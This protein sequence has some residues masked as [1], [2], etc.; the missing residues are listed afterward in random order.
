MSRPNDPQYSLRPEA[1]PIRQWKS[2]VEDQKCGLE[3]LLQL[4]TEAVQ[5]LDLKSGE[6]DPR[7]PWLIEDR[8]SQLSFIDGK[9]GAGKT[10]LMTTLVEWLSPSRISVEDA[11][12][13][14]EVVQLANGLRNRV[15]L[16]EPLDMEP[17]PLATPIM[18]AI[19]ARVN[20]AV[21]RLSA[22][23]TS[24]RGML[25]S[26]LRDSREFIRL[27]QFQA[28]IARALDTNLEQRKGSLDS[29]QYG[30][31]V[32]QQE[33]DRLE[34]YSN[35]SQV[36][37]GVSKELHTRPSSGSNIYPDTKH[38]PHL[39]LV[40]IDDVDLNPVRCVELLRLLRSYSPPQLFYLLMGQYDLV[41]SIM[42]LQIHS[43]Y[44][45]VRGSGSGKL[46][47]K[48]ADL[49]RRIAEVAS[50]NLRKLVPPSQVV[51]LSVMPLSD[52]LDFRPLTEDRSEPKLPTLGELFA[53]VKIND[54][55]QPNLGV[56]TDLASLIRRYEMLPAKADDLPLGIYPAL[57][58]FQVP[59]RWLV[60]LWLD[61]RD[62]LHP[63]QT[64]SPIDRRI[65]NVFQRFWEKVVDEDP[66]LL[67]EA[68]SRLIRDGIEACEVVMEPNPSLHKEL[69]IEEAAVTV[70]F[71]E[72]DENQEVVY[73][74]KL[75]IAAARAGSG[76]PRLQLRGSMTNTDESVIPIRSVR[77]RCAYVLLHDLTIAL[78]LSVSQARAFPR[79]S[80]TVPV[81]MGWS[82]EEDEVVDIA[83]PLPPARSFAEL[84]QFQTAVQ[85]KLQSFATEGETI[86]KR[87][88]ESLIQS[89]A[90][91]GSGIPVIPTGD[92][93]QVV[94]EQLASS[95]QPKPRRTEWLERMA[96]L[97]MPEACG[98]DLGTK[99]RPDLKEFPAELTKSVQVLEQFL[100]P[101]EKDLRARREKQLSPLLEAGHRALWQELNSRAKEDSWIPIGVR[102]KPEA[103]TTKPATTVDVRDEVQ[104]SQIQSLVQQGRAALETSA[105]TA[106]VYFQQA[107]DAA[108]EI[109]DSGSKDQQI[110]RVY[111]QA[112]MGLGDAQVQLKQRTEAVTMYQQ[113]VEVRIGLAEEDPKNTQ[114]Q[115]ELSIAH[116]RLGDV[117]LQLNQW[118]KA[119]AAYEAS[120]AIDARSAAE[121]PKNSQIQRDLCI[122]HTKLGDVYRKLNQPKKAL[123]AY[124]AAV[125]MAKRLVEEDPKNIEFQRGLSLA[126]NRVGDV[127]LQLNQLEKAMEAYEATFAMAQRLASEDPKNR[128]VQRGLSLS[129]MRLG[130]VYIELNQR[131]KALAAYEAALAIAQRLALDDPKNSEVQREL[132]FAHN[133][134]GNVY[135][136]LNELE[137]ALAAFEAD[138]AIAQR[139]A[140]ADP[141]YAQVH[142]DLWIA[143][144]GMGN[145]NYQLN[146]LEKAMVAYE[147]ALAIAQRLA[148]EDPKNSQGQLDLSRSHT[149]L[150]DAYLKLNQRE[151][152]L[153]AY[154]A[155]LAIAK[156]LA[157]DNPKSTEAQ[158]D[159][160][161][162]HIGFGDVYVQLN[163]REKAMATYESAYKILRELVS[164]DPSFSKS[165]LRFA[166]T[167][168]KLC[169]VTRDRVA[170]ARLQK[171]AWEILVRERE[172][173]SYFYPEIAE[174]EKKL[175][176][177]MQKKIHAPIKKA[178]SKKKK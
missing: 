79:L 161:I 142:R 93:W 61:L 175:Q 25:D 114:V 146:Q 99:A 94:V 148:L 77:T 178:S 151:K 65:L 105:E 141:N 124:E 84:A 91:L 149:R 125:D 158:L 42:K 23:P 32:L 57:G 66:L 171:S 44:Q 150:G 67:P 156:R 138:F 116:T 4:M 27:A 177:L 117:Y 122:A 89:W 130:D 112:Y 157:D 9:R 88:V 168:W 113:E 59:I 28:R 12:R 15:V 81:T 52:I 31:A 95:E 18:A 134:L 87:E 78:N 137:K 30:E 162:S 119:L 6:S 63:N 159:L 60:D 11:D 13:P 21:R 33:D 35:L 92:N 49:I 97:A 120:F 107:L 127:F 102:Q 85:A 1:L 56:R 133:R 70:Q 58:A 152:A 55:S 147:A 100:R 53:Q 115:R 145:A 75:R 71:E 74:P 2:L 166:E 7:L 172:Q 109:L 111:A 37:Q 98:F 118:E 5:M 43:E 121:H 62:V 106:K 36:L 173:N 72:G 143:H 144:T 104:R 153:A 140:E 176:S 3:K 108:K 19:L 174:V 68:K 48:K 165:Q 155:A 73:Q 160:S 103:T 132:S 38:Q 47:V 46:P 50:A 54:I 164:A 131:E 14:Q 39:F 80:S 17:L 167:Q 101:K 126:Q 76:V 139:L 170:K 34:L 22:P 154:E 8:R 24:H 86:S 41:D 82:G 69:P 40:P 29:E 20:Q 83:W 64:R 128:Q 90:A 10:T 45:R 26:G 136:Q 169:R 110:R 129:H 135:L 16:L 96:L 163:Q 51:E 123:P